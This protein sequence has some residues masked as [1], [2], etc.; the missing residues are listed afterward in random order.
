VFFVSKYAHFVPFWKSVQWPHIFCQQKRRGKMQRCLTCSLTTVLCIGL[1]QSLA[2]CAITQ[3]TNDTSDWVLEISKINVVRQ[4]WYNFDLESGDSFAGQLYNNYIDDNH[5]AKPLMG[6]FLKGG[7]TI[8]SND[9]EIQTRFPNYLTINENSDF[10]GGNLIWIY[11]QNRMTNGRTIYSRLVSE[12]RNNADESA[13]V[14][15]GTNRPGEYP[16]GITAN[17]IYKN[18]AG[19][20]ID[21]SLFRFD[22]PISKNAIRQGEIHSLIINTCSSFSGRFHRISNLDVF[23]NISGKS[24]VRTRSDGF[25]DKIYTA[26]TRSLTDNNKNSNISMASGKIV[27]WPHWDDSDDD[28]YV[29]LA[30]RITNNNVATGSIA[31]P[32]S[33]VHVVPGASGCFNG[34]L[35]TVTY[36][37]DIIPAPG[38]LLLC[39]IGAALVSWLR[40]RRTL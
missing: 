20:L 1:S 13:P 9:I 33:G 39:A 21:T 36:A 29:S 3:L 28:T 5:P 19:L 38:A 24:I 30:G 14:I 27:I 31:S 15:F 40:R 8:D 2:F 23:P 26:S 16:V 18:L 6:R 22:K 17:N 7:A 12:S 37:P 4:Y 32:L 25:H 10:S 11:R 34:E 35:F